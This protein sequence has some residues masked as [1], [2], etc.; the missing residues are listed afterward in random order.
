MSRF[1]SLIVCALSGLYV[2]CTS[3]RAFGQAARSVA[4]PEAQA[5]ATRLWNSLL[6][7]CEGP[8]YQNSY[9][10]DGRNDQSEIWGDLAEFRDVHFYVFPIEVSHADQLNGIQW[11]AAAVMIADVYRS[12]ARANGLWKPFKSGEPLGDVKF[13]RKYLSNGEPLITSKAGTI[14]F[15]GSPDALHPQPKGWLVVGMQQ[16]SGEL[17]Y[18]WA[19]SEERSSEETTRLKPSCALFPGTR[20]FD[21]AQLQKRQVAPPFPSRPSPTPSAAPRSSEL[22]TVRVEAAIQATMLTK[23][24]AP[25][26]PNL[27]AAARVQGVVRFEAT[28][29]TEGK[30]QN[31]HLIAGPPLLVQAAAEAVRQWEYRPTILN[32]I[33]VSV[34]TTIDVEFTLQR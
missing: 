13:D 16:R 1:T 9:F 32:G 20:E 31:V 5:A 29:N 28:I 22:Q 19:W 18:K 25:V 33:P 30:V 7:R 27:A 14:A 21:A 15:I 23:K 24:T 4:G 3:E 6:T 8:T 12:A 2:L 11:H 26:Y 34:S 10:Y 17:F